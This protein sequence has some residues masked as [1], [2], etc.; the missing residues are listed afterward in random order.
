ME[1]C[2][3]GSL[4]LLLAAVS[5][6]EPC[7]YGSGPGSI[8][9]IITLD[10]SGAKFVLLIL[11]IKGDNMALTPLVTEISSSILGKAVAS[12]CELGLDCTG[13]HRT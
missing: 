6:I 10:M 13:R 8:A 2:G 9:T 12:T 4:G 11:G 5:G 7:T 1:Y 3:I